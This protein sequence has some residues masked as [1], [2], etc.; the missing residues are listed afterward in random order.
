MVRMVFTGDVPETMLTFNTILF[1]FFSLLTA[2]EPMTPTIKVSSEGFTDEFTE[3]IMSLS[4]DDLQTRDVLFAVENETLSF[5]EYLSPDHIT[6]VCKNVFDPNNGMFG[7]LGRNNHLLQILPREEEL[8]ENLLSRFHFVGRFLG[9]AIKYHWKLP[10]AFSKLFFKAIL[11]DGSPATLDD[12]GEFDA[13]LQKN[14]RICLKHESAESLYLDFTY[15]TAGNKQVD[16]IPGGSEIFVTNENVDEYMNLLTDAFRIWNRQQQAQTILSGMVDV[17][18]EP[19]FWNLDWHALSL[20]ISS[21]PAPFNLEEFVDYFTYTDCDAGTAEV[22]LLLEYLDDLPVL[23]Q[24]HAFEKLTGIMRLPV[25]GM[26]DVINQKDTDR[27][28]NFIIRYDS[29]HN[30]VEIAKHPNSLI[31]PAI[32]SQAIMKSLM[33]A[34]LGLEEDI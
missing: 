18:G 2:M 11:P 12:I 23:G 24:M 5:L 25:S 31:L 34:V 28:W 6:A 7:L 4:P 16:L 21:C 8:S 17:L 20:K 22:Q 9:L 19:F 15:C 27:P 29:M 26:K 10:V 33:D 14:L 32:R 30:G 1:A 3:A 13:E